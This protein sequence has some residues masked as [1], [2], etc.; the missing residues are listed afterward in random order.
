MEELNLPTPNNSELAS[1]GIYIRNLPWVHDSPVALYFRE[2]QGKPLRHVAH[3]KMSVNGWSLDML[4]DF[5]NLLDTSE[6]F[7]GQR[8]TLILRHERDLITMV[9]LVDGWAEIFTAGKDRDAVE[10]TCAAV[11]KQ[12]SKED[13]SAIVPITFWALDPEKWPR[14]MMRKLE[15][16]RWS[17]IEGNYD[18]GTVEQVESLLKLTNCPSERLILWHGPAGTGKTYALRALMREWQSWCDAAF[19]TDAERFVGGSPT[20]LFQ[21][22]N[23]FGGRTAAAASKRSKLII[24]E[25]AGE[26][27]TMEARAT[28]GQGLS[29]MLN[30]TDGLMGQ[31]MNVMVLIT[32]NE[33]LSSMHPAVVRPGRCLAEI[34]F[35]A[36]SPNRA[37]QWLRAHSS[38]T[39]VHAPATLAELYSMLA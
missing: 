33:P 7:E 38:Q 5:G 28:T 25:D 17:D 23:F 36:L 15:T 35:G 22:A 14:P 29:R 4:G 1:A 20:Y 9:E 13:D 37:N 31:G 2:V 21:V 10:A 11:S 34:E 18:T 32:T 19:I 26:L 39:E 3:E 16:P 30:L 12:L 27:M 6:C 8:K 24:L